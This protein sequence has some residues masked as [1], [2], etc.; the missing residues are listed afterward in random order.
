MIGWEEDGK[1]RWKG[2]RWCEKKTRGKKIGKEKDEREEDGKKR[3][4]G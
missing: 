2:R 3:W 1:R 4:N